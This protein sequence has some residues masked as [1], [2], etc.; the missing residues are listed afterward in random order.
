MSGN[1]PRP[2]EDLYAEP[3]RRCILFPP[4]SGERPRLVAVDQ[5][6][7]Q[8]A[9]VV[10]S[11][12][13]DWWALLPKDWKRLRADP[14]AECAEIALDLL[15]A[16][17]WH[18]LT[19]EGESM[20]PTGGAGPSKVLRPLSPSPLLKGAPMP[21]SFVPSFRHLQCTCDWESKI[22]DPDCPACE[23]P[24]CVTCD[25]LARYESELGLVCKRC[26]LAP[27]PSLHDL[28]VLN[29]VEPVALEEIPAALRR[30]LGL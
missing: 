29:S 30:R 15:K 10:V 5:T 17:A 2:F 13:Q 21:L 24:A 22:E 25:S 7:D 26:W 9:I 28:A 20:C 6:N 12:D 3:S 8:G 14:T 18:E 11:S 1:Y 4:A 16:F 27:G 23:A 19:G